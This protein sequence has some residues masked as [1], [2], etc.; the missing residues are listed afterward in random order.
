MNILQFLTQTK[1]TYNLL[2]CIQCAVR[3]H[4]LSNSSV[5]RSPS[6][7]KWPQGS[8]TTALLQSILPVQ[9]SHLFVLLGSVQQHVA[10]RGSLCWSLTSPKP[11]K[12]P[13]A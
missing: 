8:F 13:A 12:T 5:T 6:I 3:P 4:N 11:T 1:T 7:G 2:R 10:C 9:N